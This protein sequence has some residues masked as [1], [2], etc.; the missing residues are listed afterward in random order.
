[1]Y[2]LAIYSM[3]MELLLVGN[4]LNCFKLNARDSETN[5]YPDDQLRASGLKAM[6]RYS[7]YF[8]Y[9]LATLMLFSESLSNDE[10]EQLTGTIDL[11]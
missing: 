1:M 8:S 5:S 3:K 6:Q 11:R 9:E 2:L 10:K 4:V 7:W